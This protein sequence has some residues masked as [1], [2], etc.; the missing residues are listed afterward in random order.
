MSF[1]INPGERNS[2]QRVQKAPFELE[3]SMTR[4]F[5]CYMTVAL[6]AKLNMPPIELVYDTQHTA[7][8]FSRYAVVFIG[9]SSE[10]GAAATAAAATTAAATAAAALTAAQQR[11][12]AAQ[13]KVPVQI[14]VRHGHDVWLEYSPTDMTFTVET[15]SCAVQT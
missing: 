1:D 13:M 4:S 15:N 14:D 9:K 5:P 3:R 2:A 7:A 11:R 6:A 12:R 10:S 8:S